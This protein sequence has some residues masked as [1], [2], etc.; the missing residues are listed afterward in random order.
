MSR[1]EFSYTE[2][3]VLFFSPY[4]HLW[5]TVCERAVVSARTPIGAQIQVLTKFILSEEQRV[6]CTL[7]NFEKL[8]SSLVL[9]NEHICRTPMFTKVV[10]SVTLVTFVTNEET[11]VQHIQRKRFIIDYTST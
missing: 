3:T 8:R 2:F 4:D 7:S 5:V 11:V 10:K 6:V 9:H 1:Y